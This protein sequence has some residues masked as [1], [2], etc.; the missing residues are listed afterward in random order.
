[1]ILIACAMLV[2]CT[3]HPIPEG[4]FE[5]CLNSGGQPAYSSHAIYGTQL[6]CRDKK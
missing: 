5:A 2:G 1:M 3:G 6:Y 4:A